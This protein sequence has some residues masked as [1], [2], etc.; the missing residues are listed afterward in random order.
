MA[1]VPIDM[2]LATN[3]RRGFMGSPPVAS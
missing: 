3:N 1:A 2:Q